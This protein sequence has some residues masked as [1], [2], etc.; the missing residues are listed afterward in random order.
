MNQGWSH[1]FGSCRRLAGTLKRVAE[2]N[3]YAMLMIKSEFGFLGQNTDFKG[4]SSLCL[5][6]FIEGSLL[7]LLPC[8]PLFQTSSF[9]PFSQVP[10]SMSNENQTLSRP[11]QDVLS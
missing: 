5:F 11:N 10:S 1:V 9:L 8:P 2:V 4:Q 6:T 3:I 7:I